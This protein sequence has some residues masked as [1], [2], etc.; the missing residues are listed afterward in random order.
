MLEQR[1]T[2]MRLR[3]VSKSGQGSCSSLTTSIPG[4]EVERFISLALKARNQKV[5]TLSLV[6]PMVNTADPDIKLIKAE[7]A[8]S[9]D[10]AEG[11]APP[12]NKQKRHDGDPVT[13]GSLGSLST[14]Y[15]ANEADDLGSAC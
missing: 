12:P 7:V 11:T 3:N 14:G 2:P 10:R 8:E 13:G 5:S 4:S 6:P 15:A 1:G 9:I